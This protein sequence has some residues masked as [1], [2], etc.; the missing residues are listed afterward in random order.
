[1]KTR[2]QMAPELQGAL[3]IAC[4]AMLWGTTGVV[5]R[6]LFA[7]SS[8]HPM[9]LALL[10]LVIACPCFL[11]LSYWRGE[12]RLPLRHQGHKRWLL[13]LGL[14]QGGYQMA[15]LGAVK[16]AGAGVATLIALCLAPVVVAILAVPLLKE[17]LTRST[18]IALVAAIAGT[19]MLAME[20]GM[21]PMDGWLL[22]LGVATLAAVIYASFT[23]T[24]RHTAGVFAPFQAAFICFL[25]GALMVFPIA[26]STGNLDGMSTL[27]LRDWL[28]VLYIG[29]IPTCL[30]YVCFFQGMR[31]TTATLSSIIVT[32]EPLFAAI[33]AWV[34]LGETMTAIGIL[35]AL[36][37]TGAV[38]VAVLPRRSGHQT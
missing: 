9:G 21:H 29:L 33:L 3:L 31:T 25:V 1:M 38:I 16:L 2:F 27:G 12:H 30:S 36:I 24:S 22:G 32:L 14:T 17:R 8:L 23:L 26:Y 34:V 18:V 13:L 7:H 15:Y 4:A 11:L 37:L 28:M 35:G 19:A 10:R 20:R 5:A 6:I